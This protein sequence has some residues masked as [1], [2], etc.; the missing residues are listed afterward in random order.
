M[1]AP[2]LDHNQSRSQGDTNCVAS[3][4]KRSVRGI[5]GR[6][7]LLHSHGEGGEAG[8]DIATFIEK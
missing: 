4:Q 6:I 8:Q 5:S 1:T 7:S 2:Q 3:L